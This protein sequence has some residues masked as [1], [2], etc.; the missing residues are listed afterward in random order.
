MWLNDPLLQQ[1]EAQGL[2]TVFILPLAFSHQST[3][4]LV[5]AHRICRF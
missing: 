3:G 4:V 1:L 2:E 5:L